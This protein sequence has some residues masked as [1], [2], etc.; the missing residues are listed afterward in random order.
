MNESRKGLLL[1][2][3]AL[4]AASAPLAFSASSAAAQSGE[5]TLVHSVPP[6]Y[7]GRALQR[8]RSG[9]VTLRFTID[10]NGAPKDIEVVESSSSIFE[11]AAVAALRQWRYA[12]RTENGKAVEW[13]GVQTVIRFG[14]G[15]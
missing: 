6:Q 4:A 14:Q 9:A 2:T 3:Y 1:L 13:P 5:P 10:V 12:P 7:P 11:D 8:G 15:R